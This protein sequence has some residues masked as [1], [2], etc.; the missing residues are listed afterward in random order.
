MERTWLLA[1]E[2][3]AFMALAAWLVYTQFVGPWLR[4]GRQSDDAAKRNEDP[5][6]PAGREGP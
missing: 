6:D 4:R 1:W 3:Y 5:V 2:F